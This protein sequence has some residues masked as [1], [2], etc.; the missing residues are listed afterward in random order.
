MSVTYYQQK[1]LDK[2]KEIY[3]T[4]SKNVTEAYLLTPRHLYVPILLHKGGHTHSRVKINESN[5]NEHLEELYSD[6]PL[7]I[8]HGPENYYSTISQPSF[9]LKMIDMLDLKPGDK[10]FE[11]GTGSGWNAALMGRMVSPFGKIISL[12][13]IP[14]LVERAKYSLHLNQVENVTVIHSDGGNGWALEAPY[15]SAIF[16]A[17]AADFPHC[18]FD[19]VKPE[20]NMIF[21]F[22]NKTGGDQLFLLKKREHYFEAL[23]TMMCSFVPVT[24]QY[25][26]INEQVETLSHVMEKY[27]V[28]NTIVH[29][30]AFSWS[31]VEKM[32]SYVKNEFLKFMFSISSPNF[33]MVEHDE[34]YI[35][36]AYVD[37]DS[38]S[39]ALIKDNSIVSYGDIE[40]VKKFITELQKWMRAGQPNTAQLKLRIYPKD[41][42]VEKN[43]YL[44][45]VPHPDSVFVWSGEDHL[46]SALWLD[47]TPIFP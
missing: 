34:G 47:S 20:G 7:A 26:V 45:V 14:E 31:H 35:S 40:A 11:L 38:H 15:D 25:Q 43:D 30:K 27:G 29:N 13:I 28:A 32:D 6:R 5:L 33:F 19:Q 18:F 10:V 21:V 24:G 16:T 2:I 8:Y 9:V 36:Y 22:K 23:D 12:E 44:W 39:L 41:S 3:P 4:L 46:L 37:P 42:W 1:L 17:G